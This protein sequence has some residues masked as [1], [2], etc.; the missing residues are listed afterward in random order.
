LFIE[1]DLPLLKGVIFF[2]NFLLVEITI[3]AI[4]ARITM[5]III[6]IMAINPPSIPLLLTLLLGLQF[7]GKVKITPIFVGSTSLVTSGLQESLGSS[8]VILKILLFDS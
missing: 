5:T 1:I 7:L 2:L 6:M 8:L 3:T 4:I